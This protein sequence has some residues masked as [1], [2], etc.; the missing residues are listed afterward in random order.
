MGLPKDGNIQLEEDTANLLIAEMLTGM[1]PRI[2]GKSAYTNFESVAVTLSP[3]RFQVAYEFYQ[4]CSDSLLPANYAQI[5]RSTIFWSSG[6][7]S[8]SAKS[9]QLLESIVLYSR[10][11]DSIIGFE[12]DSFTDTAGERKDNLLVS[13]EHAFLVTNYLIRKGIDPEIIATRAHGEREEY[14]IVSPEKTQADR[15][16]NRRVNIVMLQRNGLIIVK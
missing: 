3:L 13:E 10:A 15:N 2:V 11:D 4:N 9:M 1:M 5:N 14:L 8:H 6:A 12:I 16:R 7:K